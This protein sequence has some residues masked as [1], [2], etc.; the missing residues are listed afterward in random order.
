MWRVGVGC[1]QRP[2][3]IACESG[4]ASSWKSFLDAFPQSLLDALTIRM[5]QSGKREA[6]ENSNRGPH[7]CR[8][9]AL[10]NAKLERANLYSGWELEVYTVPF[11]LVKSIHSHNQRNQSRVYKSKTVQE[12]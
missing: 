8:R 11:L 4:Q 2:G 5:I 3:S 10:S 12:S 9:G 6:K 1:L 7:L